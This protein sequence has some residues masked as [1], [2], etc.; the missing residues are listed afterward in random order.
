MLNE[1]YAEDLAYVH[2]TGFGDFAR[3]AAAGLL[4]LLREHGINAGRVV[5]LGCGSG[6]WA[7]ELT[8]AGY[9][10]VGVDL[11]AAMIDIARRRAPHA[12]FYVGSFLD[13]TLPSCRAVTALGEVLNYRFDPRNG[14]PALQRLFRRVFAALEP[15]GLFI[16]DLAGPGR[17]RNTSQR[18]FEGSDWTNLVEF[19]R[20]ESRHRLTRRIVTFR[21]IGDLWR[22]SDEEH[23]L[24]LYRP[25]EIAGLLRNAGFRVRTV[26]RYGD[27][28]LLPD[29]TG[30]VARRDRHTGHSRAIR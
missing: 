7:A 13:A 6:L 20:D 25:S 27:M 2:D 19:T 8:K 9:D 29:L 4:R 16:C 23:P 10:T 22:R 24:Q 3:N 21:K 1:T 17:H 12:E 15:G 18:F 5:D 30:F 28:E 11:S 26:R 14:R